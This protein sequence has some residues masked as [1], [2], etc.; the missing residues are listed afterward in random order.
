MSPKYLHNKRNLIVINCTIRFKDSQS[1]LILF[2]SKVIFIM[3]NDSIAAEIKIIN[4]SYGSIKKAAVM[5][6][7][8]GIIQIVKL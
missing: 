1:Y 2:A 8:L 5:N 7:K 3:F 6:G 4:N